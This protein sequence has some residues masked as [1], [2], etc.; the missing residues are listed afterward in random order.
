MI[1]EMATDT[2]AL[3]SVYWSEYINA[4]PSDLQ[5]RI[6][7]DIIKTVSCGDSP[8]GPAVNNPSLQAKG[9]G[10]DPWSGN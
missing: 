6:Y 2:N 1:L 4:L 5:N 10:F 8:G 7:L 9:R 3:P